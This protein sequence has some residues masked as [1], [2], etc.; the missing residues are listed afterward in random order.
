MCTAAR[1]RRIVVMT[2]IDTDD[3]VTANLAT[4]TAIYA[5]FGSGDVPGL[6]A[7][8]D[9]EIS[10]DVW[11]DNF[12]QRRG[13]AHLAPR[14]GRAAVADFFALLADYP[15]HEFQ[16]HDI[17]ANNERA[18]AVVTID[19]CTPAGGRYRDE[20]LHLWTLGADG[21]A[22]ALRHYVDTAK[23]IAAADGV[24]TTSH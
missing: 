18:I 23:H 2:A 15:V 1:A 9:D 20:E 8:L 21:R 22:T 13:V 12:A 6:L 4:V 10:W 11:P 7:R 14:V 19:I 5:A 16:V 17:V 3:R 24:D